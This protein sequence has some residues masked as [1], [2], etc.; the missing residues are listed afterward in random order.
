MPVESK[1]GETGAPARSILPPYVVLRD[2]LGE[3]AVR[4]L[5]EHALAH[6]PEFAATRTQHGEIKPAVRNSLGLQDLGRFRPAL[7]AKVLGALPALIATLRVSAIESPRLEL[8]LVAHGDGAFYKRHID[9][10]TAS[11]QQRLR[12]LSG[13]YYFHAEPKAFSGGALRLH[14]I[15]PDATDHVDIEPAR[16]SLLVFPSWAPH[17][18]MPVSCPS[19]KFIDSRFAINC[20]VRSKNPRAQ[21][22]APA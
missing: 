11:D 4:G 7:E 5:L 15:G 9:T 17:E 14:A 12:A 21:A 6:E 10:Q 3:D 16:D 22:E 20:W 13:V 1:H 8:Q 18:V 2:F 19:R